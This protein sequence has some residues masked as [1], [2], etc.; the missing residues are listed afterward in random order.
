MKK[1][2][3]TVILILILIIVVIGIKITDNTK[4]QE[5]ISKFNEVFEEY[6][7]KTIYGADVYTIINKAI[8]NNTAYNIK[9]DEK[10]F[11]IDDN[12]YCL[13]VELILLSTDDKGQV[14]EVMY[15]M[16]VLQKAGLDG[17]ISSFSLTE[18]KCTEIKYNQE[19][20][21]STICLKQLE[22]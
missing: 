12:K 10:G 2:F 20:R 13:K 7:N 1:I 18:F 9:K 4:K 11:Y 17:F 6:K 15:Q 8:D 22:I 14:N 19:G 16:E 5:S 21:I 3:G